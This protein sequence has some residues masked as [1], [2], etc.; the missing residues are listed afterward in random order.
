MREVPQFSLRDSLNVFYRQATLFKVVVILLPLAT[1]AA[2]WV[3][4]PI[5]ETT[6]RIMI[7]AK[8]E[9]STLLQY[10][11]M[12]GTSLNVDLNVGARDL[13][14]EMEILTSRNLWTSTVKSLGVGFFDYPRPGVVGSAIAAL[15]QRVKGL[16][17][18][19][20]VP[21]GADREQQVRSAE[22]VDYLIKNFK[23]TSAA[24]SKSLDL[25]LRYPDNVKA[26][27]VMQE[28]LKHYIP[29]HVEVYS[30][31]GAE[32]FFGK[33]TQSY[34]DKLDTAINQLA[35]FN[36]KAGLFLPDQQKSALINLAERTRHSLIDVNSDLVQYDQM[37]S[38]LEK[39]H[40]PSGQLA[41]SN[42]RSG[43]NTFI[44]ILASQVLQA[45]QKS[46]QAQET[47]V[48]GTRNFVLASGLF[49]E[50]RDRFED[51][52]RVARG[53]I[54]AKKESLEKSL[55]EVEGKL[56]KLEEASV[57]A[58]KLDLAVTVNK[59]RFL[60]YQSKEEEARIENLKGGNKLLTVT[61]VETP[62]EPIDPVFPKTSF[63][64]LAAFLLAIPVGIGL[65]LLGDFFDHAFYAPA[66][67]GQVTG[68][69]VL[70]TMNKV[71]RS[72]LDE[73][74]PSTGNA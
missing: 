57:H 36:Q 41:L 3:A 68:L 28:L 40:L 56:E 9:T 55:R 13:N 15:K 45:E 34:K 10:P 65:V 46:W 37:L 49:K 66:R 44:T 7:T 23:V 32:A 2:C 39:G 52:I 70:T 19:S 69:P 64:V 31:P 53:S 73:F 17:G 43:E 14:A 47:Y 5:Y 4:N 29:Y 30:L 61:V 27:A 25:S 21:G 60:Q 12:V 63:Y 67:L 74:R 11:A 1:L 22:I 8:K 35:D 42:E 58:K 38:D 18:V 6:A 48:P 72:P 71:S 24:Q 33:Q 54:V 59:E 26:V 62:T 16:L 50:L 51:T 20:A